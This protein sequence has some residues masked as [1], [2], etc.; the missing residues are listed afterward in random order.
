TQARLD[1]RL[2]QPPNQRQ[3]KV[4]ERDGHKELERSEENG[5]ELLECVEEFDSSDDDNKRGRLDHVVDLVAKRRN[6][7]LGRLWQDD[8]AHLT[9][10]RH[11]ERLCGVALT[12][13]D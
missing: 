12:A 11:P 9:S 4:I 5:V 3:H 6:D 1:P 7:H 2:E 10:E 8:V 13:V